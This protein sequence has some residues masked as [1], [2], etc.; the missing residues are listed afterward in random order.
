MCHSNSQPSRERCELPRSPRYLLGSHAVHTRW[1]CHAYIHL[2][3]HDTSACKLLLFYPY[4][5][6]KIQNLTNQEEPLLIHLRPNACCI[7]FRAKQCRHVVLALP[8]PSSAFPVRAKPY[9]DL[10]VSGQGYIHTPT[11]L[12]YAFFY[13]YVYNNT[14]EKPAR[15]KHM[16]SLADILEQLPASSLLQLTHAAQDLPTVKQVASTPRR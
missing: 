9:R 6:F 11:G 3:F 12:Q 2:C 13:F 14:C 5:Q 8:C 10:R 4:Y 15:D 7:S 16:H 1:Y